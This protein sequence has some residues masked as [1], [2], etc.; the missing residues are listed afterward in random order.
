MKKSEILSQ[1]LAELKAQEKAALQ[2]V[3]AGT[4][5]WDDYRKGLGMEVY[6]K[7][8]ELEKQIETEQR[9]EIEVG[10]GATIYLYSDAWACTVIAK[11]KNSITLQRDHAILDYNFKPQFVRGGFFGHCVNDA[12]QRYDYERDPYGATYKAYWSEKAGRYKWQGEVP[13]GNGRHE[14]YDY[15]F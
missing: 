3:K 5:S 4:L 6:A 7:Q 12:D 11:T 13:V 1:E 10:D 2:Q 14:R 8:R 9:R 15:N